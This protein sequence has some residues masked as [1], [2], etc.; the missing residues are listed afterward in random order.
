MKHTAI[1]YVRMKTVSAS[2]C[3]L[4]VCNLKLSSVTKWRPPCS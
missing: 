1:H 3:T 2:V 4:Y